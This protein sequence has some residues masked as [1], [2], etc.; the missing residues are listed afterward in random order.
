M[1]SK[2]NIEHVSVKLEGFGSKSRDV[3]FVQKELMVVASVLL[4]VTD[5]ACS[6]RSKHLRISHI[7]VPQ[8]ERGSRR[9]CWRKKEKLNCPRGQEVQ[10]QSK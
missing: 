3:G 2:Q 8:K 1:K 9:G 10:N 5:R 7:W 6:E 4:P